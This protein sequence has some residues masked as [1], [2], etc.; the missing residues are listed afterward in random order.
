MSDEKYNK[1][2]LVVSWDEIGKFEESLLQKKG[3]IH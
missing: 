3:E 1:S 2:G